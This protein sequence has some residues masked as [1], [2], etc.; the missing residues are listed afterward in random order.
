[1]E[2]AY[3][4]FHAL[5]A[6]FGSVHSVVGFVR[7][8]KLLRGIF[9]RHFG[10]IMDDYIDDLPAFFRREAMDLLVEIVKEVFATLKI[11]L[12]DDKIKFGVEFEILG[13]LFS[14]DGPGIPT[15]S[16][17]HERHQ[18]LLAACRTI[19]SQTTADMQ[20]V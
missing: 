15:M 12:R 3:K 2:E 17:P 13:L 19:Q 5:T 6:F 1:M 4:G 16:L 10:L 11:P 18:A 9:R 7:L 20:S 8:G 14:L